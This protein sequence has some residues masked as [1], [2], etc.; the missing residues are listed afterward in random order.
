MIMIILYHSYCFI[1]IKLYSLFLPL[2]LW[3]IIRVAFFLLWLPKILISIIEV[4][5]I[6]LFSK[7]VWTQAE[8]TLTRIWVI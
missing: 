2:I 1:I 7:Y 3:D 4:I 5:K 8:R 6:L